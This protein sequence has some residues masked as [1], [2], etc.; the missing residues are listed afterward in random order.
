MELI[1]KYLNMFKNKNKVVLMDSKWSPIK[2]N[3]KFKT[4][5][6]KDEYIYFNEKYH[7]VVNI[8]HML[9]NKQIIYIIIEEF[10]EIEMKIIKKK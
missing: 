5:P 6:N 10:N 3:V 9:T 8:I 4:I 1:L 7:K 2:L